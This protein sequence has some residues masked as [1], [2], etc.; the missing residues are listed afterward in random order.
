VK[1]TYALGLMTQPS[2]TRFVVKAP[3]PA[4]SALSELI[5]DR[6]EVEPLGAEDLLEVRLNDADR[7]A[8]ETWR[9][10]VGAPVEWA[11]PAVV[12]PNGALSYPTGE[13]SVRFNEPPSDE[14]LER[15]A[16]ELG[17]LPGRRNEYVAEQAVFRPADPK[18]T[19]LPAKVRE[20]DQRADVSAAW[21]NTLSRYRR[22]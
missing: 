14:Q 7:D 20:I 17:L 11:A 18:A 3:A 13:L 10:I 19:Y 22:M 9:D 16:S 1:R 2:G 21:P 5:G 8:E 15:F 4:R 6:G 12:D